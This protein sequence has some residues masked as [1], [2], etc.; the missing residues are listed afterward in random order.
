MS[1]H[2]ERMGYTPCFKWPEKT[3]EDDEFEY[4]KISVPRH[5]IRMHL[6][7]GNVW[8]GY[9]ETDEEGEYD[10]SVVLGVIWLPGIPSPE[11]LDADADFVYYE[12]AVPIEFLD[13]YIMDGNVQYRVLY[14]TKAFKLE[15][16]AEKAER[17]AALME[18]EKFTPSAGSS[19]PGRDELDVVKRVKKTKHAIYEIELQCNGYNEAEDRPCG[20]I[21]CEVT[22]DLFSALSGRMCGVCGGTSLS[23][24]KANAIVREEEDDG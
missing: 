2:I 12:I 8:P 16:P 22:S 23:L 6:E 14:E 3:R 1:D 5:L 19:M 13:S 18:E 17:E 24:I 10:E 4:Y 9:V 11:P 21:H 20:L 7:E 15:T